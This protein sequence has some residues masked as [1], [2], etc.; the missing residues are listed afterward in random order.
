MTKDL[1]TEFH[2]DF[3]ALLEKYDAEFT[4][5]P[6]SRDY[7][8]FEVPMIYFNSQFNNGKVTREFSEIILSM[9]N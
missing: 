1:H 8:T 3:L 4:L 2:K 9:Y 5:K 6:H 7:Y